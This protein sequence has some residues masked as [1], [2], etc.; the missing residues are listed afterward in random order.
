MTKVST[1]KGRALI[2]RKR[3]GDVRTLLRDRVKES[4]NHPAY[5]FRSGKQR[6]T[7]TKSYG[8]FY[9]EI[10]AVG[11]AFLAL[12]LVDLK[13]IPEGPHQRLKDALGVVG[14]NAYNWMVVYTAYL[15]GLGVAI[16]LDK[17]L[18][19]DEAVGLAKR[20]DMKILAYTPSHQD[21]A[22]AIAEQC[23]TI[24]TMI[25]LYGEVPDKMIFGTREVR[26]IALDELIKLG[27]KRLDEGSKAFESLE[28]HP[29]DISS[30]FFTSGTTARSKGVMLSHQAVSACIFGGH[31]I[32]NTRGQSTTLSILPLHHTFENTVGQLA[33]WQLGFTICFNDGLRH[34]L[35]NL[36][37]WNVD[38][39]FMVP[40]VLESIHKKVVHGIER[41]GKSAT[42][43]RLLKI[44]NAL[45]KVGI[46]LRRPLFKKVRAAIGPNLETLFVGGAPLPRDL[47]IFFRD[48]GFDVWNAYGLTECCPGIAAGNE[49]LMPVGS[50][51]VPAAL[52]EF[53][54]RPDSF[55]NEGIAVGE[56]E[57]L[58]ENIMLG[59]Y[60]DP[61]ATDA[62]FTEDGWF[63]TGD[64][65]YL[66][67]GNI[68]ITGREKSM[69]VLENGK[70]VFP[71][72]LE[73]LMRS[74]PL[75]Q[76]AMLWGEVN[77]RGHTELCAR[78]EI[79]A[80]AFK[81]LCEE[82]KTSF[83]DRLQV[84][85]KEINDKL[86]AY[87]NIRY[88]FWSEAPMIRTTTKKVKRREEISRVHK[89]L[90]AHGLSIREA[91]GAHLDA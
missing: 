11:E 5:R 1:V 55:N 19:S 64:Y 46:D 15:F 31:S 83:S 39:L 35:N 42:F 44:S 25:V 9:R 38:V 59:Y 88:F 74:I 71:E 10:N 56:V 70:N 22:L 37:E 69:I 48:I 34:L 41:Q 14:E 20:S 66:K 23:E 26:F 86:P 45:R 18:L 17:D 43:R 58:C 89:Y 8:T 80:D 49:K 4:P 76:D 33:L 53:R 32:I 81:K 63:R 77:Q 82:E 3:Y 79:E 54:I 67:N 2:P 13:R 60:R 62:V 21:V 51:G 84:A 85:I 36:S 87:K 61:K 30:I 57:V 68:F 78:F 12:G 16:P 90:D 7:I 52:S 40:L 72:E 27:S 50:V 73:D 47:E 24:E 75:V 65:G 91:T 28:L 29:E 6:E